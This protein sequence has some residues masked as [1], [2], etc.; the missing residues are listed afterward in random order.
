MS[1]ENTVGTGTDKAHVGIIALTHGQFYILSS[2]MGAFFKML[3][4][5]SFHTF[6]SSDLLTFQQV[7]HAKTTVRERTNP[8]EIVAHLMFNLLLIYKGYFYQ[9]ALLKDCYAYYE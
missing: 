5:F 3:Q 8:F 7:N 2:R 9:L 4:F 6:F 1:R